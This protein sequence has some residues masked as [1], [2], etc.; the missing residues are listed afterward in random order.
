MPL[1]ILP[2]NH[3]LRKLS[4]PK[5]DD[6]G[7]KLPY[8]YE[9]TAIPAP[10]DQTTI[11]SL[12]DLSLPSFKRGRAENSDRPLTGQDKSLV[13]LTEGKPDHYMVGDHAGRRP[14]SEHHKARIFYKICVY[15]EVIMD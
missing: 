3:L 14:I 10:V 1:E 4:H 6:H 9:V 15:N 8:S 2:P 5:H 7:I 12:K 13:G 11:S